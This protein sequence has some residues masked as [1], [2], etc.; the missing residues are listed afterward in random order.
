MRASSKKIIDDVE[1]VPGAST[2]SCGDSRV[3]AVYLRAKT[4]APM[5]RRRREGCSALTTAH[6][7]PLQLSRR[8]PTRAHGRGLAAAAARGAGETGR[9]RS[10][11]GFV[12]SRAVRRR[13]G[14]SRRPREARGSR[15]RRR[16]GCYASLKHRIS[17]FCA[18][19]GDVALST[20]V[21]ELCGRSRR[22]FEDAGP[23]CVPNFPPC[24][25]YTSPSPRDATLSRM[26]SS[27]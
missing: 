14:V 20:F 17:K 25:L 19:E 24:L 15:A 16:R 3:A 10:H 5:R 8:R 9:A 23:H 21:C 13:K 11:G 2:S 7:R 18:R 6:A 27:A 12:G 1:C 22:Q 26:P 4:V